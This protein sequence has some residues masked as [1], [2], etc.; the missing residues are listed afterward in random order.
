[1]LGRLFTRSVAEERSAPFVVTGPGVW[2]VVDGSVSFDELASD[3]VWS[4]L[5][6][7]ASSVSALPI[8]AVAY[9]G[10]ARLPVSPTPRVLA[11][12]SVLVDADVWR[13]QVVGS[14]A[15]DGNAFG[16]VESVDRA[17]NPDQIGLLNPSLVTAR[18]TVGGVGQATVRGRGVERLFPNGDLWHVPGKMARA[19]SPFALSPVE[20]AAKAIGAGLASEDF[21][22]RFFTDGAHPSSVVYS[23]Q[24]LTELQ[25]RSVKDSI[26]NATRG[27]RQPAVLGAG[28][29]LEPVSV[30]PNDSQFLELQRYTVEKVCRFF[31]V[32][33]VMVYAAMS[34]QNVTY[35]NISQADLHYLKWSLDGYLVRIEA[36]LTKLL[37]SGQVARINRGALLRADAETRHKIY[38]QRL[39]N[40]TMTVNE[41]R[42]LEDEP[43][44]DGAEF[45][46]PGIPASTEAR[47]SAAEA[48]QKVYLGVGSVVTSDEAREIVNDAGGSLAVPGPDL[49]PPQP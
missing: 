22:F 12:P 18:K 42:A 30:P 26:V 4:C 16:L 14:M 8:D 23:E 29:K 7:L 17:G 9:R 40:K 48:V 27:N 32:P 3:A 49:S 43:P 46:E 15:T 28:L 33:P 47:L 10:T 37:P 25:A 24:E 19:G 2:G 13:Y 35:A 36:A 20:H 21:G 11:T 34:G 45:D 1:M 44:F 38:D 39:K 41:V 31:R 5:D 6:V